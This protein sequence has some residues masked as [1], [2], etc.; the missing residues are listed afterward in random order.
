MSETAETKYRGALGSLMQFQVTFGLLVVYALG[1]EDAVNWEYITIMCLV[2]PGKDRCTWYGT[3][4]NPLISSK[5]LLA[6]LNVVAMLF[7]PE[8]PVFYVSRSDDEAARNSLIRLRGK[9][10][11]GVDQVCLLRA[12]LC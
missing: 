9:E 1:I 3:F 2:V 7:M 12:F 11:S 10:Y 6:V 4:S 5:F 8:S